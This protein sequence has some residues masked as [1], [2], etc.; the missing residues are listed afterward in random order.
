[1][2]IKDKK[3]SDNVIA[4]HLSILEKT[5]EKEKRTKIAK[6]IPDKQLF[7]LSM[8][9]PWYANIIDYLASGVVPPELNYQ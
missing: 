7:L 3:G 1:M 5:A 4:D 8:K 2:E 9:T 6:K